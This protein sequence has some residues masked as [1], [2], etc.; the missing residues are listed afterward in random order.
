[1]SPGGGLLDGIDWDPAGSVQAVELGVL[2]GVVELAVECW[3]V[4]WLV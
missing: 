1:M 3:A 4:L 2:L